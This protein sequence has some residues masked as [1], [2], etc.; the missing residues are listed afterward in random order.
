MRQWGGGCIAY[1]PHREG[2]DYS[3]SS[4]A[5]SPQGEDVGDDAAVVEGAHALARAV[6]EV[7][8]YRE[9]G[10]IGRRYTACTLCL[11]DVS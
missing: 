8:V 1:W 2:G 7:R 10:E 4:R 3:W 6:D 9:E 11:F 5:A